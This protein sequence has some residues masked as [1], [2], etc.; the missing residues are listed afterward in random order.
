[1]KTLG[2]YI[3]SGGEINPEKI[4][5]HVGPCPG[6]IRLVFSYAKAGRG[7]QTFPVILRM[8]RVSKPKQKG[9]DH[10]DSDAQ[11]SKTRTFC[12]SLGGHD[13]EQQSKS[14]EVSRDKASKG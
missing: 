8:V 1:V 5:Y 6:T 3:G 2:S 12:R 10:T 7:G 11:S 14:A 4:R 13:A 9:P